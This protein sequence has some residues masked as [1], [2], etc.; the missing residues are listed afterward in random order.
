MLITLDFF[1]AVML[2]IA[3]ACVAYLVIAFIVTRIMDSF[4]KRKGKE[5]T[6]GN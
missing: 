3:A 4:S 2:I 6:D 1:D 5:E